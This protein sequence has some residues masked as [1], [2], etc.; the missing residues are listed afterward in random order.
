MSLA[1]IL[2]FSG[3]KRTDPVTNLYTGND[4]GEARRILESPPAGIG[5]TEMIINPAPSRRKTHGTAEVEAPLE[6]LASGEVPPS[7]E[8]PPAESATESPVD[9]PEPPGRKKK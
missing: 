5:R 7:D 9:E 6:S 1:I 2:G 8:A 4:L 3:T